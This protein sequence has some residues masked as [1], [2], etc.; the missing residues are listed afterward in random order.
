MYRARMQYATRGK[1]D[2]EAVMWP[3]GGVFD[4]DRRHF[5]DGTVAS[6]V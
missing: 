2:I 3:H 6:A 4:G 5:A 1:T